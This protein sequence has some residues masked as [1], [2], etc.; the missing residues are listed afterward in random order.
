MDKKLRKLSQKPFEGPEY[1]IPND[2]LYSTVTREAIRAVLPCITEGMSSGELDGLAQDIY[3][4]KVDGKE[5]QEFRKIFAVLVL[6]GKAGSIMDFVKAG[7]TDA[8]LPLKK[9]EETRIFG[10]ALTGAEGRPIRLFRRWEQRDIEAFES[11]QWETLAPFFSRG[12]K[13]E[14]WAQRYVLSWNYPLPFEIIPPCEDITNPTGQ[15]S[16]VARTGKSGSTSASTDSMR[17]GNSKVWKVK[18]HPAHHKLQSYR[19]SGT[20][21]TFAIK[22]LAATGMDRDTFKNEVSILTKLNKCNDHHLVKLLLAMEI[23]DRPEKDSSTYFLMFPLADGNLRQFWQQHF[24]HAGRSHMAIYGRWMAKQFYGLVWALCKLHDLHNREAHYHNTN[25]NEDEDTM[26]NTEESFYGIHGDI[27]PENLLWYEKWVGPEGLQDCPGVI[28]PSGPLGVLQLA[29]FGISKLHHT[30]TRSNVNMRRATKTYAPP[31]IEWGLYECSRSF[32]IWSLGCVFLEFLCW[33]V[34][35]DSG[36]TNP[37]DV[38]QQER[39]LNDSNKSLEGTLQDTFYQIIGIEGRKETRVEI[40]PAVKELIVSLKKSPKSS[41]FVND[42]L[43]IILDHMLVVEPKSGTEVAK[44][45][46]HPRKESKRIDCMALAAKLSHMAMNETNDE[47]FTEPKGKPPNSVEIDPQ[48]IT[49]KKSTTELR[50]Q[51]RWSMSRTFPPA[52]GRGGIPRP[53]EQ[54]RASTLPKVSTTQTQ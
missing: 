3:G 14:S 50:V 11:C 10:L 20:T 51:R 33:L 39:Y 31:E 32:D 49:I 28:P 24:P 18:I 30:A 27:K 47:Y 48:A 22:R 4:R 52:S 29:D 12:T 8:K 17:G 1:Y 25:K 19:G 21:P 54:R 41:A 7:I 6:I 53:D 44:S 43:D 42:V 13:E 2:A 26:N 37:V 34:Q 45:K 36:D 23:V 15:S 16:G 5:I 40:N 9:T 38:F 46:E 35:G